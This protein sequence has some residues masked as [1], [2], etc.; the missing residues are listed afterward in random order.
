VIRVA[1]HS[2]AALINNRQIISIDQGHGDTETRR[3]IL[4]YVV[5]GFSRT[6]DLTN[7]PAD[8]PSETVPTR[9]CPC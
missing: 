5:S 3:S 6:R 7:P 1:A 4:A 9:A 2:A 8:N